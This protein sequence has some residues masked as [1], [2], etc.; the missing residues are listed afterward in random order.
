VKIK[1]KI[2]TRKI[3]E[4]YDQVCAALERAGSKECTQPFSASRCL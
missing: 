1:K 3:T 2:E 4:N